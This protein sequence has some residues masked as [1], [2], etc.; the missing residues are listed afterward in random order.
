[1]SS[2]I[3][4]E[5]C[6]VVEEAIVEGLAV[7]RGEVSAEGMGRDLPLPRFVTGLATL[8][9]ALPRQMFGLTTQLVVPPGASAVVHLPGGEPAVY[10][11]GSYW[12]WGQPG[13]ALA[14]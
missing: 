14:Q 1:M 8:P 5:T 7:A 3:V 6:A 4:S 2:Q 12:L 10:G 13:L 9:Q 11:P